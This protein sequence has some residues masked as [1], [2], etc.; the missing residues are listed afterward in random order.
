MTISRGSAEMLIRI[1]KYKDWDKKLQ[2]GSFERVWSPVHLGQLQG[3][4]FS[5]ALRFISKDLSNEQISLNVSRVAEHGFINY[6]GMQRFGSYSVRTHELG[7]EILNQNW[8]EVVR[9][10]LS[11]HVDYDEDQKLRKQEIVSLIFD[12]PNLGIV[13]QR[14][15]VL[16]AIDKLD[17]RDRLEKTV[18]GSLKNHPN[19]YY[20]AFANI[21]K[22]TRFIY[23]H[24]YQSYV[25]NKA[26][27]ERLRRH[28]RKVLIGDLVTDKGQGDIIELQNDEADEID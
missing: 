7:K 25:W 2:L 19:D 21:S 18:L 3:N 14:E 26:V 20:N 12:E 8:K 24:A 22:G 13:E 5:V 9:M 1:Q 16:I 23:I 6:F 17:K 28:G 11:Q 15:N 10:I 27:S 4:R